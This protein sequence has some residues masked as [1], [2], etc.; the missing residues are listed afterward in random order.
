[1]KDNLDRFNNKRLAEELLHLIRN[2]SHTIRIN[3]GLPARE[4]TQGSTH[5]NGSQRTGAGAGTSS[6]SKTFDIRQEYL[7]IGEMRN[8]VELL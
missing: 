8:L 2:F 5:D 6:L 7:S 1:M 4:A 3:S